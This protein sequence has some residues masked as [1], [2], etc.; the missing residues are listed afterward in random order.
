MYGHVILQ[1]DAAELK[2]G[3]DGLA[4]ANQQLTEDAAGS[5]ALVDKLQVCGAPLSCLGIR[6]RCAGSLNTTSRACVHDTR[7]CWWFL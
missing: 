2:Q 3:Y 4:T 7:L 5:K 1:V 6:L